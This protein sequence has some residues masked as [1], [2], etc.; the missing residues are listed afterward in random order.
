MIWGI[1]ISKSSCL[2]T[3]LPAKYMDPVSGLPYATIEAFKQ[4]RALHAANQ[5]PHQQMDFQ[6]LMSMPS[7]PARPVASMTGLPPSPQQLALAGYPTSS[8]ASGALVPQQLSYGGTSSLVSPTGAYPMHTI[9]SSGVG[10]MPSYATVPLTGVYG[11][12]MY[13]NTYLPT[14]TGMAMGMGGMAYPYSTAATTGPLAAAYG[15]AYPGTGYPTS[16]A[17]PQHQMISSNHPLA[18]I[19]ASPSAGSPAAIAQAA[20]MAA[21]QAV[22]AAAASSA[23]VTTSSRPSL[24]ATPSPAKRSTTPTSMSGG[25]TSQQQSPRLSAQSTPSGYGATGQQMNTGA[26]NGTPQGSRRGVRKRT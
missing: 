24:L 1:A 15:G 23:A 2:I 9:G 25:N 18:G 13:T 12:P 26:G 6:N 10:M 22:A 14:T 19:P 8:A 17:I 21:Q 20:A 5:L 4:L 7:S 3:G 16:S 11:Q